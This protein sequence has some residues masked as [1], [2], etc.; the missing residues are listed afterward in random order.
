MGVTNPGEV[1]GLRLWLVSREVITSGSPT[2]QFEI[3]GSGAYFRGI[4][5]PE[6][7]GLVMDRHNSPF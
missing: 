2:E 1:L 3:C 5:F 6:C 4:W 7:G